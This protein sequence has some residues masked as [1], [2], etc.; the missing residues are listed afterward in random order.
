[1]ELKSIGGHIVRDSLVDGQTENGIPWKM[2]E[3][4]NVLDDF[5]LKFLDF[6][7]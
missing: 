2:R 3:G 6:I 7:L 4:M 5:I 1:M